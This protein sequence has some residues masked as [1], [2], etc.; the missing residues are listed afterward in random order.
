ML[1]RAY[2]IFI[3]IFHSLR[4]YTLFFPKLPNSWLSFP[5]VHHSLSSPLFKIISNPRWRKVIREDHRALQIVLLN[6]AEMMFYCYYTSSWFI[7][8]LMPDT[9]YHPYLHWI[10]ILE[11]VDRWIRFKMRSF[12]VEKAK[13]KEGIWHR[14]LLV[15][16]LLFV[17]L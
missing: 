7:G 1:W 6:L 14:E 8:Y 10:Y 15:G 16:L 5:P 12:Q 3:S 17:L 11:D 9:I 2:F 4:T 13:T